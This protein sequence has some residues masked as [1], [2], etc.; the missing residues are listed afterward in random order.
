MKADNDTLFTPG[1]YIQDELGDGRRNHLQIFLDGPYEPSTKFSMEKRQ[2]LLKLLKR[3][4][5]L[6]ERHQNCG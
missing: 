3:L 4:P 2:S 1:E 6:W 5:Q